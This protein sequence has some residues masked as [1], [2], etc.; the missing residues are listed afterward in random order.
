M[1]AGPQNQRVV[2]PLPGKMVVVER[3]IVWVDEVGKMV[4][5][6]G[7]EIEI[8]DVDED[9]GATDEDAGAKGDFKGTGF[10]AGRVVCGDCDGGIL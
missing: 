2:S 5:V 10:E 9:A 3:R 8:D 4:E 7:K 1:K 6:G